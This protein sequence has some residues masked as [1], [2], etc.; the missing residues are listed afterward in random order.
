M[1]RH[2]PDPRIGVDQILGPVA[3][4]DVPIHDEHA[5]ESVLFQRPARGD[6]DVVDQA[7][8]HRDVGACV[9]SRRPHGCEG[10]LALERQAC[11][12]HRRARGPAR[13]LVARRAR[14][15]ITVEAPTSGRR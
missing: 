12:E 9:V 11:G 6:H 10:R 4:V 13:R 15:G 1:Q 14:P 5:R 7:E 2:V 8:S 3:V